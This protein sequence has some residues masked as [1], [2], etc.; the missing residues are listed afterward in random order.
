[1]NE[2]DP[3]RINMPFRAFQRVVS[4][5]HVQSVGCSLLTLPERA[6]K[7]PHDEQAAH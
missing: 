2:N 1:M 4:G 6:D 5:C 3:S 7:D